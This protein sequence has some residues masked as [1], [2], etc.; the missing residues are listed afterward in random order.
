MSR[1]AVEANQGFVTAV[2]DGLEFARLGRQFKGKVPAKSFSR[3]RDQLVDDSGE[4]DWQVLGEQDRDGNCFLELHLS[5]VLRLR[6]Q[7]CL[8]GVD[9]S[10]AVVSRLLLI[11]PGQAWPDEELA[12]DGFDAVAAGKEMALAPMIEDEML[13]A[14]P[15]AP[16]HDSCDLPTPTREEQEPSPFAVLAKLKKGA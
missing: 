8:G 16:R 5:G 10:L 13:L 9:E 12:E 15:I 7:R 11:P 3:L 14:L 4:I 6:C 2:I 1:Q